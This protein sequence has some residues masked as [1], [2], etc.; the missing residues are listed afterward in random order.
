VLHD[1]KA[2]IAVPVS[3]IVALGVFDD[4]DVENPEQTNTHDIT[5]IRKEIGRL[6]GIVKDLEKEQANGGGHR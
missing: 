3:K 1:G 5:A 2:L 4:R 6:Y